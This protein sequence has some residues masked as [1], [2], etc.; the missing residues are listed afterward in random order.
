MDS[1][2]NSEGDEGDDILRDDGD[3][4]DYDEQILAELAPEMTDEKQDTP[5][6]QGLFEAVKAAYNDLMYNWQCHKETCVSERATQGSYDE[7]A[8]LRSPVGEKRHF[9]VSN[10]AV[11]PLDMSSPSA[12][13]LPGV[14]LNGRQPSNAIKPRTLFKGSVASTGTSMISQLLTE[15]LGAGS[16]QLASYFKEGKGGYIVKIIA[17]RIYNNDTFNVRKMMSSLSSV[18]AEMK[19][20]LGEVAAKYASSEGSR[21]YLCGGLLTRT[22]VK[23]NGKQTRIDEVDHKVPCKTF[24]SQFEFVKTGFPIQYYTYWSEYITINPRVLIDVYSTINNSSQLSELTLDREFIAMEDG[25]QNYLNSKGVTFLDDDTMQIFKRTMRA[26]LLE[27]AYTHHVCNQVKSDNDL[28]NP[29]I[30][31]AFY[32]TLSGIAKDKNIHYK[33]PPKDSPDFYKQPVCINPHIAS[34]EFDQIR[35]GLGT[36]RGKVLTINETALTRRKNLVLLEMRKIMKYGQDNAGAL[37]LTM[38]RSMIKVITHRLEQKMDVTTSTSKST[39]NAYAF[40][41]ASFIKP[42]SNPNGGRFRDASVLCDQITNTINNIEGR[43]NKEQPRQN[44]IDGFNKN[45]ID[46]WDRFKNIMFVDSVMLS[47]ELTSVISNRSNIDPGIITEICKKAKTYFDK[48]SCININMFG[49]LL[50]RA[51]YNILRMNGNVKGTIRDNMQSIK[52]RL[53]E[54]HQ[55]ISILCTESQRATATRFPPVGAAVASDSVSTGS[56][57]FS[58]GL[59]GGS[60]KSTTRKR[61]PSKKPRRTIRRQRRNKKGT[62]KRRK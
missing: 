49:K 7:K 20:I 2:E 1:S 8:V 56:S 18:E 22:R 6:F 55:R 38:K 16:A 3:E 50:T 62:Q 51:N 31:D 37:N 28:S 12:R 58:L 11:S 14:M 33:I 15:T 10:V 25:F 23:I 41:P 40:D 13:F 48:L 53:H 32:K 60:R 9:V 17:K 44:V 26:Y 52:M 54:I 43:K 24:Y 39:E 59:G 45:I 61:R 4:L 42:F 57:S 29:D 36:T 35:E 19:V 47:N 5:F 21:C 30:L 46:Y 34:L 27:F